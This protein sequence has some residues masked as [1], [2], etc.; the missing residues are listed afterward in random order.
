VRVL[1]LIFQLCVC[2]VSRVSRDAEGCARKPDNA[3]L[4]AAGYRVVRFT[5]QTR[6]ATIE[7]RLRALLRR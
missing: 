6:Q 4:T 1:A 3:A 7:Q 5:N 2:P